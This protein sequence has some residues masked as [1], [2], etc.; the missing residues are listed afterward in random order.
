MGTHLSFVRSATLDGLNIGNLLQ[1][2]FGGNARAAEFFRSR[3]VK[4][5]VDYNS[6]LAAQYKEA[7]KAIVERVVGSSQACLSIDP[8]I[9]V[10][11]PENQTT[12][13]LSLKTNTED[14]FILPEVGHSGE[15]AAEPPQPQAVEPVPTIAVHSST[16]TVPLIKPPIGGKHSAKVIDDDFDFDSVPETVPVTQIVPQPVSQFA[17]PTVHSAVIPPQ[18]VPP[19][20]NHS[21]NPSRSM[22]S[23]NFWGEEHSVPA[24]AR[25]SPALVELKEK[26][27]ELLQAGKNLY[28]SFM[29]R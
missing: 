3:G 14:D 2:E 17:S 26:S 5:K 13:E 22:S 28:N 23:S 6:A 8:E 16:S 9:A 19:R 24:S 15:M 29:H 11:E 12:S 25:G 27:K 21:G 7:L 4:G 18:F 20:D 1:M 10:I